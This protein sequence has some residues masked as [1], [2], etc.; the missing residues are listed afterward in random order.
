MKYLLHART[1]ADFLAGQPH[2][3]SRLKSTP[4]I[5]VAVASVSVMELR[6]A[7]TRHPDHSVRNE[8]VF[9]ALIGAT[10][11]LDFNHED[12]LDAAR[13]LAETRQA[14]IEI[15]VLDAQV[16][17]MARRRDLS[18]IVVSANSDVQPLAQVKGLRLIDWGL[19]AL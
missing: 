13:I 16:C 15:S 4:P 1:I 17:A 12:A 9:N 7:F 11:V 6:Y 18:L 3:L 10:R 8:A 19:P 5:D 2:V 14:D